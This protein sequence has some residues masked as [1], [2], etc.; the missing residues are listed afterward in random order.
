[1]EKLTDW[2]AGEIAHPGGTLLAHLGRT[3]D[4]LAD[5]GAPDYL[6]QAGLFHAA[7]ATDGFAIPLLQL[8]QRDV[9]RDQIGE[10]AE[11][12]VYFYASCDRRA[13][14]PTIGAGK[15]CVFR[16]RYAEA[17]ITP[18]DQGLRGFVELTMANELDLVAQNPDFAKEFGDGFRELF[19]GWLGLASDAAQAHYKAVLGV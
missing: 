6:V 15:I 10:Q 13:T 4:L 9:L 1:M 17:N 18:S 8:D 16:D 19:G 11:A 7:Y 3:R 5:W 2:G 12:V 14:Y